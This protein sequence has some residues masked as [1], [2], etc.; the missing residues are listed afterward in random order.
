M[1]DPEYGVDS[2]YKSN[3]ERESDGKSLM[4]ARLNRIKME[5]KKVKDEIYSNSYFDHDGGF[6][7]GDLPKN[8]LPTDRIEFQFVEGY[9]SENDSWDAH[10]ELYVYREREETDEEYEKRELVHQNGVKQM[11]EQRYKRYLKLKLEFE[12]G[13]K[14]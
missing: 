7:Y 4:D 1:E 9:Y 6:P 5:K 2:R 12:G 3:E 13:D 10:Y 8:L 11:K 14:E